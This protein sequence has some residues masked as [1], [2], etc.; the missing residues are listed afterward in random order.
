MTQSFL[1]NRLASCRELNGASESVE[2][3]KAGD[4]TSELQ[5]NIIDVR[6]LGSKLKAEYNEMPLLTLESS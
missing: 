2:L 1:S 3:Q 6:F 5:T 4:N